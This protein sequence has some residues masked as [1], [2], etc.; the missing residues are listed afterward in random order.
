MAVRIARCDCPMVQIDLERN[1]RSLQ[2][3]PGLEPAARRRQRILGLGFLTAA[4]LLVSA[5]NFSQGLRTDQLT[6]YA[7]LAPH[8][9]Q[10]R[11]PARHRAH[12]ERPRTH[13][14]VARHPQ[15]HPGYP[16]AEGHC[17]AAARCRQAG[18]G[19]ARC[20]GPQ[21]APFRLS[22]SHV[23]YRLRPDLSTHR[24]GVVH[25][26]SAD[27]RLTCL[28]GATYL[29]AVTAPVTVRYVSESSHKTGRCPQ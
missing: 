20:G 6:A 14:P 7:G 24:T 22:G 21:A 16:R 3:R 13:C 18:P 1:W 2:P 9:H 4:W 11:G 17:R 25:H 23:E 29:P 5:G 28:T 15:W 12:R 10:S 8:P 27:G 19:G 26:T